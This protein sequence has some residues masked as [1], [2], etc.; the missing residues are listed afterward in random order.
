[1]ISRSAE[2]GF[3]LLEA[4]IALVVMLIGLL[5]LA[6]LQVV[7]VRANHFAKRM[8]EASALSMDLADQINGW[9]Y[10]DTRLQPLA[11]VTGPSDPGIH[12]TDLGRGAA[13]PPF[14]N[15]QPSDPEYGDL[16]GDTN[17]TNPA[18]RGVLSTN[19]TGLS[20]DVLHN[21]SPDYVRYWNVYQYSDGTSNGLLLQIFVRWKEPS[22]GYRQVYITTY[23]TN[24]SGIV[25]L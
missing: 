19:Y 13:I 25:G 2:R 23:K 8:S 16:A 24:P 10:A 21:G 5:G 15:G 9:N 12:V 22:L 20:S 17:V 11:T 14:I 7:G 6:G 18:R 1:M 4:M 3:T